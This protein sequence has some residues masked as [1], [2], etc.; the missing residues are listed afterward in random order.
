VRGVNGLQ[1][2]VNLVGPRCSALRCALPV[3]GGP[4][5]AEVPTSWQHACDFEERRNSREPLKSVGGDDGVNGV[6][7]DAASIVNKIRIITLNY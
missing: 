7:A 2:R 6:V 3:H 5:E 1:Q 4:N